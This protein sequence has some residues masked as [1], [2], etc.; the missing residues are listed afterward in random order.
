MMAE[1]IDWL[2]DQWT[3]AAQVEKDAKERKDELAA[4]IMEL[5]GPG[6]SRGGIQIY[7]GQRRFDAQLATRVLVPYPKQF[8]LVSRLVPQ[9]DLAKKLLPDDLYNEMIKL[10]RPY[11]RLAS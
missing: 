7:R 1:R 6:E 3:E 9:A 4:M 10:S 8:E 5:M 2:I 11:I